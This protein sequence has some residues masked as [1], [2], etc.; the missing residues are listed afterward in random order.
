MWRNNARTLVLFSHYS[1]R[2]MHLR[3]LPLGWNLPQPIHCSV[4]SLIGGIYGFAAE[5][6]LRA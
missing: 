2:E 1:L 6:A 5:L 3:V 4:G